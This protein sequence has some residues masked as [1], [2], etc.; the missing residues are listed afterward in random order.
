MIILLHLKGE[1]IVSW[2]RSLFHELSGRLDTDNPRGRI[3]GI[4]N[5][6]LHDGINVEQD[7][8][9]VTFS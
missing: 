5:I 1:Q 9:S 3:P 2:L 8:N 7:A 6:K 4:A